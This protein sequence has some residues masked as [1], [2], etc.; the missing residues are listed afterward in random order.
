MWRLCA[1]LMLLTC[2][3]LFAESVNICTHF[4]PI[5]SCLHDAVHFM[6]TQV[7]TKATGMHFKHNKPLQV[8]ISRR[9]DRCIVIA[10]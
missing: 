2:G 9:Y 1:C 3:T 5:K 4:R 8:C 10:N 7:T 6:E